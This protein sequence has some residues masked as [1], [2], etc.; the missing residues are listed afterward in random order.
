MD[1]RDRGDGQWR[2]YS[3]SVP[4]R[5]R[6]MTRM[7]TTAMITSARPPSSNNGLE[8]EL[9]VSPGAGACEAAGAGV[10]TTAELACAD[11]APD[12]L[13][14]L[15]DGDATAAFASVRYV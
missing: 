8:L 3:S 14:A 12:A 2:D 1:S 4:A 6:R 11:G 15:G 9:V 5:P 13:A 7:P 10:A